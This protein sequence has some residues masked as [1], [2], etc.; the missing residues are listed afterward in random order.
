MTFA[1]QM[2]DHLEKYERRLGAVF[3]SSVQ[4]MANIASEPRAKGGRMPVDTGMLRASIRAALN[5][6]P[7]GS[8]ETV[9]VG[10]A[11][12]Q[13]GDS[14]RIGWTVNYAWPMEARYGFARGAAEQWERIVDSKAAQ[15]KARGL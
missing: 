2:S 15:A 8:S 7:S 5:G 3:R 13:A 9:A 6:T 14:I 1:K 11:Q 4:E 10:L 12:W